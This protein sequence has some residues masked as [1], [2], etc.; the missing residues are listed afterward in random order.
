MEAYFRPF[1]ETESY[2][3]DDADGLTFHKVLPEGVVPDVDMGLV[4]ATGPTHKHAG[5]HKD[6]DQCYLVFRGTG[7]IHLAGRRIRIDRPGIA[8]IPHG[9]EHSIEVDAGRTMQYVYVN[10]RLE[11]LGHEAGEGGGRDGA[12]PSREGEQ[13]AAAQAGGTTSVSSEGLPGEA[14]AK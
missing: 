1:D 4:T 6:F 5:V 9:T 8:V 3:Q 10:R 7:A 13:V 14:I 2:T 12:R 11:A